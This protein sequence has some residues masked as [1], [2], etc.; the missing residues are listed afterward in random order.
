MGYIETLEFESNKVIELRIQGET[1]KTIKEEYEG[2]IY[3]LRK[4]NTY[5]RCVSQ[6]IKQ[7]GL[8]Y[9]YSNCRRKDKCI[10]KHLCR[11]F[12]IYYDQAGELIRRIGSKTSYEFEK[13]LGGRPGNE[14][15]FDDCA[16]RTFVLCFGISYEESKKLC[17][18]NRLFN[19]EKKPELNGVSD[20]TIRKVFQSQNWDYLKNITT[21]T[22]NKVS[23]NNLLFKI[24][25]L[26]KEKMSI[27]TRGHIFCIDEGV[28]KDTWE[29]GFSNIDFIFSPVE[30]IN[31]IEDMIIL[32]SDKFNEKM[33]Y[34][35]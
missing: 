15:P 4:T 29:D 12:G 22:Q 17:I 30:R 11:I 18:E 16:V 20:W 21:I 33:I 27:L 26:K 2:Y 9:F 10:V 28:I 23:L 6:K 13:N 8:Q 1:W 24:P 3:D 35:V 32:N 14:D 5:I 25:E 7:I 31:Y 19:Y 34:L